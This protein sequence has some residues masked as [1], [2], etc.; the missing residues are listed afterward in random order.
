[1]TGGLF[2]EELLRQ[3]GGAAAPRLE[4]PFSAADIATVIARVLEES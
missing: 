4:K 2:P 3:A 1:M